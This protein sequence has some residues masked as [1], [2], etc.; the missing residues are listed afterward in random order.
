MKILLIEDHPLIVLGVKMMIADLQPTAI[1][2]HTG[3]FPEGLEILET[4]EINLVIL[5]IDIPG[6]K[7][8]QMIETIRE[9]KQG[10][11]ILIH[12]GYDELVYAVPYLQA[13]A[14][15]FISKKASQDE[16]KKAVKTVVAKKK[17]VSYLVQQSLLNNNGEDNLVASLSPG[18]LQV[19]QLIV[20]GK[21]TKEIASIMNVKQNTVST[22]KRRIF[23][24]LG[25]RDPIELSKKVALMRNS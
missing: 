17:Y 6:G 15:G 22:Y 20:E 16:F 7:N 4:K 9:K 1:I 5:D 12:S 3:T 10:V 21:W 19:M 11:I 8:L 14:N 24:K 13:G 2:H 18:E 23:D 25:V